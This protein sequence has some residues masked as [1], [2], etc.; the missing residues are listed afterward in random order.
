MS[1][2]TGFTS[3]PARVVV[4]IAPLL[5]TVFYLAM[6]V[7][8]PIGTLRQP[9][10]GL[11]PVIVGTLFLVGAIANLV[12]SR[13]AMQATVL[14]DD[15]DEDETVVG[16]MAWRVP[17]LALIMVVYVVAAPLAGHLLAAAICSFLALRLV[18]SLAVWKQ[19]VTAV[20]VSVASFVLFSVFLGVRLP[21]WGVLA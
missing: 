14:D 20:S 17:T 21:M 9:G 11:F 3:R 7:Q 4:R 13:K 10:M 18:S 6:A 16:D 15:S 12:P 2:T 1:V 19:I 8:L 5:V